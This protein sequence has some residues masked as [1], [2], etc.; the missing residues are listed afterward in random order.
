[1]RFTLFFIMTFFVLV[2]HTRAQDTLPRFNVYK[3]KNG[4]VLVEWIND[5]GIVK[6]I[7]VQ[8]S[9]DSL[10]RYASV[11]SSPNPMAKKGTYTDKQRKGYEY[12]YRIFVQ[13]PEGQYF[14]TTPQKAIPMPPDLEAMRVKAS[15]PPG[16]KQT[17]KTGELQ[18]PTGQKLPIFVAS[19][20][21]FSDKKG[22][23]IINLPGAE[24]K[25]FS[26][27]FTDESGLLILHIPH[28]KES[29]LILEK[30]NFHKSGWYYFEI[31]EGERLFEKHKVQVARDA[32]L[33][34]PKR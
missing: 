4:A 16:E 12:Y 19:D 3:E 28:V 18:A 26:I 30:Y 24:E 1:M 13:L 32:P 10:R 15:L 2:F 6:Q 20:Y 22:H 5:Y 23:V 33:P 31:F 14:V 8:R 21:V 9:T 11:F 7:T 17:L 25:K 34:A 29:N 27:K